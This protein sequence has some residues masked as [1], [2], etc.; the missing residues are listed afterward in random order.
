MVP[1]AVY[2]KIFVLKKILMKIRVCVRLVL[3]R[4]KPQLVCACKTRRHR[5]CVQCGVGGA[6]FLPRYKARGEEESSLQGRSFFA[7]CT[8][9]SQSFWSINLTLL[10]N[11]LLY[12][13][14]RAGLWLLRCS[15]SDKIL[16]SIISVHFYI[17]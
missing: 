6:H 9:R 5:E 16:H 15:Y 1:S 11:T 14:I 4:V 7:P 10:Q 17:I 2:C 13:S 12:M 3:K 8:Q